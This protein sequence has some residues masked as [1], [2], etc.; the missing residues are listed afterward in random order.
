[1]SLSHTKTVTSSCVNNTTFKCS[2]RSKDNNDHRIHDGDDDDVIFNNS[3]CNSVKPEQEENSLP[4]SK[5][6]ATAGCVHSD[7]TDISSTQKGD[8]LPENKVILSVPCSL[9]SKKPP[10]YSKLW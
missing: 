6:N 10:L 9:H 2:N 4:I 7:L 8:M 1:M 3:M 5:G